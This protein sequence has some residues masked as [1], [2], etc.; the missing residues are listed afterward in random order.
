L[1]EHLF[2]WRQHGDGVSMGRSPA[3]FVPA[4]SLPGTR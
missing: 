2:R 4:V 1:A 3:G